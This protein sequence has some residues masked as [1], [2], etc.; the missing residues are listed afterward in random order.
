MAATSRP[1]SEADLAPA[2]FILRFHGSIQQAV[3]QI[4][5]QHHRVDVLRRQLRESMSRRPKSD[6]REALDRYR[7]AIAIHFALE[8]QILFPAIRALDLVEP[9]RF[10]SLNLTHSRILEELSQMGEQF[11]TLPSD[12]FSL[13][14]EAFATMY[15][16][17]DRD[18]NTLTSAITE[19]Q[20]A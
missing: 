7:A 10:E 18:E 15:A 3:Q 6:T 4:S 20:V 11:E 1:R 2:N 8:E 12:D 19:G 14:L 17:C 5:K 9:S 13:R 16:A